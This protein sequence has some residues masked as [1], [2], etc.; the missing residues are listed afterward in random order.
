MKCLLALLVVCV[1]TAVATEPVATELVELAD[2][3]DVDVDVTETDAM[4]EEE[5]EELEDQ[6]EESDEEADEA[7][8]EEDAEDED[9]DEA[10]DEA[11]AEAE[12]EA[13][14]EIEAQVSTFVSSESW[15]QGCPRGACG[16]HSSCI[17]D[18]QNAA[19]PFTCSCDLG[20]YKEGDR[21]IEAKACIEDPCHAKADCAED[22]RGG[23]ACLCKPGFVGDGH[24]K[25]KRGLTGCVKAA[26]AKAAAAK[27]KAAAAAK[28]E[29]ETPAVFKKKDEEEEDDE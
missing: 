18:L 14:A 10:D 13:D 2:S 12:A 21:C 9:E 11:E 25:N 7:E 23:F 4:T 6:Q 24:K 19:A 8:E 28:K 15:L 5:A 16:K 27:A 1:A 20:F 26:E 17:S 29:E 3:V 22:G